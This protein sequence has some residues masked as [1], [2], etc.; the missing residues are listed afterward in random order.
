MEGTEVEIVDVAEV[1]P[2]TVALTLKTPPEFDALPG[3]FLQVRATVDGDVVTRHYSV[4]SP[5]VTET[6]EVTVGVDPGGTLSPW[7]A[8]ATP[9]ETVS[10]DGPYG[11]VYYDGEERVVVL[12]SGP[13]IGPAVGV[14]ERALMDGGEAA[15]VYLA[16]GLVHEERLS[17]L[18]ASG[19]EVLAV[20]EARFGDAVASVVDRGQAFV[21]G[22]EPF[23][24]RA[25]AAL[26]EAGRDPATAMVENFG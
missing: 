3:Q 7:L 26:A 5:R 21:Y 17:T 4:S 18:A 19:A 12:A 22:F 16:E 11:R 20:G 1:G 23:A 6:F 25:E 2:D 10:V 9:G 8:D 14:G 24:E 13:G 15:V